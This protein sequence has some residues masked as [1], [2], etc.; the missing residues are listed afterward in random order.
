MSA[1]EHRNDAAV[2][3]EIPARDFERAATFYETLLGVTLRRES[4]GGERLGVF[5]YQPPGVGGALMHRPAHR[6]ADSGVLIYLNCDGQLAEAMARVASAGGV[7]AGPKV[8]LPGDMGSFVHVL[9]PDG[10]RIGLHSR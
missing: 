10:N 8:E 7:L 1:T 5:P 2:W 6:P 4:I 9:D 3:F